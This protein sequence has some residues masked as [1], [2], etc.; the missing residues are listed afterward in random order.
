VFGIL[1][2]HYGIAKARHLGL[3]RNH[4]RFM[5]AAVC[6]DLIYPDTSRDRLIMS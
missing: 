5:L 6:N 1:K 2:Q 4:A 3:K